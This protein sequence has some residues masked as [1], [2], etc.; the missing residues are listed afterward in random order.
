MAVYWITG[1]SSGIGESLA[2]QLSAEGTKLILSARNEQKLEAVRS[3]LAHPELTSILP[4]DLSDTKN[5]ATVIDK[6]LALHGVLDTV[7]LNAGISQ[8]SLAQE[9]KLEVYRDL[10]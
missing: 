5:A 1:A 9:T 3:K 6:A 10:M 4:F 8:R 2:A 7:I